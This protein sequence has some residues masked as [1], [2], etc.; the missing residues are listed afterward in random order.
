MKL[1]AIL[2]DQ[3]MQPHYYN[4]NE[5]R[6]V[7]FFFNQE[8]FTNDIFNTLFRKQKEISTTLST[9]FIAYCKV[10][11]DNSNCFSSFY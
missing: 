1:F 10:R 2:D 5:R 4:N 11:K 9:P 6:F 7:A 3:T 8:Y